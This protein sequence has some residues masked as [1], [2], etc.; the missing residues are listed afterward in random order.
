MFKPKYAWTKADGTRVEKIT[1]AWYIEYTD[2]TGRWIRRKAG[3]T[4]EQAQDALRKAEADVLAEKNGL[5]T[6]RLGDMLVSMELSAEYIFQ[7]HDSLQRNSVIRK[8]STHVL[9]PL[10]LR[11]LTV[12][13]RGVPR[14][15]GRNG[16]RERM[17]SQIG[18][19]PLEVAHRR[20]AL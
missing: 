4:K 8:D 1:E 16:R 18:D 10:L 5:P 12:G 6:Q 17:G 14:G 13:V 19:H 7:E 9:N 20:S 11:V 15:S 3:I 2:A